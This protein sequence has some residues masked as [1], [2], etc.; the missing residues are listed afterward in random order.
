[1][2][3]A[4]PQSRLESAMPARL[5]DSPHDVLHDAI[6]LQHFLN[7]F[8]DIFLREDGQL[9]PDVQRPSAGCSART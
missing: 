1:M 6:A 8:P 3:R 7:Q 4:A 2:A 9:G 5:H